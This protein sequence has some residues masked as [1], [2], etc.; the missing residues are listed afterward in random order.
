MELFGDVHG[1]H[2]H[3]CLIGHSASEKFCRKTCRNVLTSGTVTVFEPPGLRHVLGG[4]QMISCLTGNL[5]KW[6]F[7]FRIMHMRHISCLLFNQSILSICR[8]GSTDCGFAVEDGEVD[9][10]PESRQLFVAVIHSLKNISNTG[11]YPRNIWQQ[12]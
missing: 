10:F 7:N 4:F 3:Q 11:Q 6:S 9:A 1:S 5:R 12:T 2:E 8:Y